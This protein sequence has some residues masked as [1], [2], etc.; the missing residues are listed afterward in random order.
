[1]RSEWN[2][3]WLLTKV[4]HERKQPQVLEESVPATPPTTRHPKPRVLGDQTAVVTGPKGEE[5]H[6]DPYGRVKVQFFWDR[7]GQ[8]DDTSSCWL[9]V[10][11]SWAGERYGGVAIPRIGMEVL[12]TFLEGDPDQPV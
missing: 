9:R 7:E 6:C 12:V 4:R 3:L 10:S 11:S 2:D 1:M 5:I 8:G